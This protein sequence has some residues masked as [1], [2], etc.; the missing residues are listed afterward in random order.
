M[1]SCDLPRPKCPTADEPHGPLSSR[2]MRF[3][4]AATSSVA[5]SWHGVDPVA[6]KPAAE[7]HCGVVRNTLIGEQGERTAF[8]V[9]YFEIA[10][11]GNTS[12][13]RHEHEHVVVV[14]RGTGR[15]RLGDQVHAVG[16]GDTIYVAP[17]EVHQLA[18]EA[19]DPFG[20]LCIVDARRDMPAAVER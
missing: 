5:H 20:F 17:N 7:H 18:N 12:L 9:R 11:G 4:P 13:E 2:I 1:N 19:T 8:H 16:Y 3:Q 10:P 15:V 6:Y 14:L